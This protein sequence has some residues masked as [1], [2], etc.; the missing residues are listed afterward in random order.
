MLRG[1]RSP[2]HEHDHARVQ[3]RVGGSKPRAHT[4]SLMHEGRS[5][6]MTEEGG[7]GPSTTRHSCF[8]CMHQHNRVHAACAY[9]R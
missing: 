7:A 2:R 5:S 9:P 1:V 8:P 3:D 6:D 4:Y